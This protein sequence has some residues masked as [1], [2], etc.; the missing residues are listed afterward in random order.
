MEEN[1]K[2]KNYSISVS[3]VLAAVILGGAWLYINSNK[4]TAVS[5]ADNNSI[6]QNAVAEENTPP[7]GGAELLVRWGDLGRKMVDAGVIDAKKFE[8][9]YANSGG[10]DEESKKLLYAGDNG[11]LKITEK[12][13]G[14][15]LNLLWALGLG[16]KNEILDSGPMKDPRY[17]GAGNFASTGGWTIAK[18]NAMEHYSLHPFIIL[19]KEQEELVKRVSQNIYRP[20]CGN[21]TY[22]PDCNHGMA[23][24]AL[25][26]LMASQGAGEDQMY[27]AALVVNSYW[28]PEQYATIAKYFSQQG[29]PWDKVDSKKALAADVSSS[30]GYQN[31]L[32]G[33]QPV[34]RQSGGGC[35]V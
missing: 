19:T 7:A 10:L 5:P 22:F 27:S 30:A 3:L 2:E 29:V 34:Q 13:A 33:I 25:L 11:N 26:E 6:A 24:L 14:V 35:G 18:G 28:F 31:I 9:V 15:V 12:N 4:N 32:S 1:K 16:N 20:C 23:M 21:S 8:E 17:G